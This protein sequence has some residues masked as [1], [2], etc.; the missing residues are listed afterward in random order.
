MACTYLERS[1]Q[2]SMDFTSGGLK[3]YFLATLMA[4]EKSIAYLYLLSFLHIGTSHCE[5]ETSFK[6]ADGEDPDH[7]LGKI[8]QDHIL[9]DELPSVE[10]IIRSGEKSYV[11]GGAVQ[12]SLPP[13]L[14]RKYFRGMDHMEMTKTVERALE[15]W[16]R[17][18]EQEKRLLQIQKLWL[19]VNYIAS[20]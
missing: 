19:E 14:C 3:R 15:A 6:V 13:A 18:H 8:I 9:T 16:A 1:L 20:I 11:P 2:I 10:E 4:D 5:H 7:I 12:I 17:V